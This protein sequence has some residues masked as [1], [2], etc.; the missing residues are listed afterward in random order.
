MKTRTTEQFLFD[1]YSKYGVRYDYSKCNYLGLTQ[2]IIVICNVHGDFQ[3]WPG[4]HL[5]G[6]GCPKCKTEKIVALKVS[7]TKNFVIKAKKLHPHLD[8]SKVNYVNNHIKVCIVCTKHGEFWQIPNNHL[9]GA[10]CPKCGNDI[11]S[12]K[13]KKDTRHFITQAKT[14]WKNKYLYQNT[15]YSGSNKVLQIFCKIHG[16]FSVRTTRFLKEIWLS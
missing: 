7:N 5:S 8:Y 2:K 10:S 16:S 14:I 3:Q 1:V 13:K 12:E 6:S 4:D 9:N 15:V 11:I